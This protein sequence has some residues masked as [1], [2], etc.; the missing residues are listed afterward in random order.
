MTLKILKTM[1][2]YQE[3]IFLGFSL[4]FAIFGF[5]QKLIKYWVK[6]WVAIDAPCLQCLWSKTSSMF[7]MVSLRKQKVFLACWVIH[8]SKDFVFWK[9]MVSL[10]WVTC[11]FCRKLVFFH[12]RPAHTLTLVYFHGQLVHTYSF[13]SIFK[14]D[15]PTHTYPGLFSRATC[16]FDWV[17][18]RSHLAVSFNQNQ[19]LYL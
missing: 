18:L 10:S 2:I 14:G 7:C 5:S 9:K 15:Q 4:F 19:N 1:Q 17:N 11:P 6:N 8:S 3:C 16:P 12:G 13:W